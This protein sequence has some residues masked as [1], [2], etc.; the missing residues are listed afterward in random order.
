MVNFWCINRAVFCTQDAYLEICRCYKAIAAMPS[1]A[2]DA[3]RAATVLRKICWFVVLAP[4]SS[5]QARMSFV[6][7]TT[8]S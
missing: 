2:A 8:G 3:E 5:D 6:T 7:C 1:V 4:T